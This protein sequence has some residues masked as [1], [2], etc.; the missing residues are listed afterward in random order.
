MLMFGE[1][2]LFLTLLLCGCYAGFAV[3]CQIGVM[4]ALRRLSLPAY[5]DTFR[6]MDH[7]LDRSMPPYRITL[8][9]LN[10]GLG[11][12]ALLLHR[13]HLAAAVLITFLCNVA[14][15]VLTVGKQIPLNTRLKQLPGDTDDGI[16]LDIREQTVRNFMERCVVSVLGFAVLCVGA[17][18]WPLRL[19][20]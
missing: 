8:L 6:A 20:Q 4:P 15:L 11:I 3:F 16:L 9:V 13:R 12:V 2:L 18:L 1:I 7:F 19:G 5:A 10:L 17:V 14:A